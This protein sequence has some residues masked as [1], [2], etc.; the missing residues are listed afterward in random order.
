[1]TVNTSYPG[2]YVSE[3]ASPA[4]SVSELPTAVPIIVFDVEYTYCFSEVKRLNSYLDYL[5]YIETDFRPNK[6]GDVAVKAYFECGGGPCYAV[7]LP[8]LLASLALY[9]DITLIVAA[10][11][12][13][14]SEI[15]DIHLDN[16]GLFAILDGPVTEITSSWTVPYAS[17]PRR[18]VYYPWLSAAWAETSIPPSSALAGVYCSND[19]LR[20]VWKTPANIVLPAD[21]T[22][23][24]KVSDSLQGQFNKGCAINMIRTFE[25]RG[26][27]VWG[28]RTLEDSDAWRYI[29]VRRLFDS[30][31]R[32]I[33]NAMKSMVFETNTAPTWAKVRS[34]ITNY[35]HGLWREGA[36]QGG[37]EKQAYFV[38]IGKGV[39]MSDG[40][41]AQGKMIACVGLAAVR[42]AE[43]IILQFTQN[44]EQ[45]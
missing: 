28:G 45:G 41:I 10:G 8:H 25:G 3:D 6:M 17:N 20:G 42:P 29:G 15:S 34:A 33:S 14:L 22:P 18:A 7:I 44:M 43:F 32:D 4:I 21:L 13:I 38:Q 1:M 19:R 30:A 37:T 26:T 2:V 9:P 27:V 36:L 24:F 35:L 39:T 12:D 40:D 23:M 31:E 5:R 16:S 11:N